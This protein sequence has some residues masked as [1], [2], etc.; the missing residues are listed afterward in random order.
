MHRCPLFFFLTNH[1]KPFPLAV[2]SFIARAPII[3]SPC[4]CELKKTFLFPI[5]E[6]VHYRK[7]HLC[8]QHVQV[9]FGVWSEVCWGE[10]G[11]MRKNNLTGQGQ[12]LQYFKWV[13]SGEIAIQFPLHPVKERRTKVIC[14][15]KYEYISPQ[16]KH[17]R[18]SYTFMYHHIS[19]LYIDG[20]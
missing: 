20:S 12:L 16:D 10:E 14:S 5:H 18:H 3:Y 17:L 4:L 7:R 9:L 1:T 13:F 11:E 2:F 15:R 8:P 6:S 19:Q